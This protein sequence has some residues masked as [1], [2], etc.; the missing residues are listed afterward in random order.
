M[1]GCKL[2]ILGCIS[3]GTANAVRWGRGEMMMIKINPAVHAIERTRQAAA[4]AAF[5]VTGFK[6]AKSQ[7]ITLYCDSETEASK[8]IELLLDCGCLAAMFEPNIYIT[9]KE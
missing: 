5:I 2:L 8:F 4:S 3:C 7:T 9:N 6:A 1:H